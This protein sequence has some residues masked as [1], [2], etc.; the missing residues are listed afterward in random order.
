MPK[1]EM[2][3]QSFDEPR[4]MGGPSSEELGSEPPI[5][6]EEQLLVQEVAVRLGGMPRLRHIVNS[7]IES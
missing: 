6:P 3:K 5:T 7:R 2:D 4:T 1:P